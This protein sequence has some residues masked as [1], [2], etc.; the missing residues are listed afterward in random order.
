[1]LPQLAVFFAIAFILAS[2]YLNWMGTALTFMVATLL[3]G[4]TGVLTP[5]E[6]LVGF[7]NEQI[8]IIILLLIIGDII[9]KK[10]VLNRFFNFILRT[11]GGNSKIYRLKLMLAVAP[12][13]SFLNN[14]PL[15]AL[16]MPYATDW[17]HRYN[18]N[19]SKL[20]IPLSYATILGGSITLIGTS[21]NLI[22]N[23]LMESQTVF[24]DIHELSMFSFSIV[25]IPMLFIGIIY[26]YLFSNKL[27]PNRK[28]VSESLA[29]N[30]R[31]YMVDT[32]VSGKSNLIG[33]SV[34][35]AGLRNLPGLFLVEITH[36]NKIIAPVMPSHII[37]FGDV[38]TFAGDTNTISRLINSIE[39][40]E[41]AELGMYKNKNITRMVEIV[42][43]HNSDMAAKTI[44]EI[45][46][47]GKFDAVVIAVHR[48][49]E[50]VSG[51][52]GSIKLKP[53]DVLLLITGE[54][55]NT[56][57]QENS[58]F[59]VLLSGPEYVKPKLLEGSIL[60]G[61]LVLSILLSV[62]KI[63]PLFYGISLTMILSLVFK[64]VHPKDLSKSID[65]DL[66]IIIA[67]SLALGTAMIK[68]GVAA[69]MVNALIPLFNPF[70]IL[71]LMFGLYFITTILAAY[72]T[73]KAAVALVFPVALS[74][75]VTENINP[76]PLVLLVAFASAANFLTPIGYQ[77][78]LMIYGPGGYKFKDYFKIG[79]PLTI[80]YM[81]GTVGI[82]YGWYF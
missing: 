66:I 32:I 57:S 55:F 22:V 49:G 64:I 79:L 26:L 31:N 28:P 65:Y 36:E 40:L 41:P 82:L 14:T 2:L 75:A 58:D 56:L 81:I 60:V 34:L 24:P 30:P 8:W 67:L 78:N 19:I 76:I 29:E 3:L 35:E 42:V 23:G 59:Y 45:G 7:G 46:F 1:M 62:F 13:S 47:R 33:K 61:G 18:V 5:K 53:G 54:D 37:H 15:V 12:L 27:L 52:I 71:G 70:G 38:L 6:L 63:L 11:N 51:K 68:T 72:I 50:K 69:M 25:G 43:S 17:A 9:R 39:G 20:L 74:M 77:T 48:N 73:N 80:L 21:T 10:G 4:L 16:T 44:K